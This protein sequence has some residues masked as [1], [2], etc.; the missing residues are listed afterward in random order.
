MS[1][2]KMVVGFGIGVAVTS[3]REG[4][5]ARQLTLPMPEGRGF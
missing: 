1:V 2:E 5:M 3:E 4:P